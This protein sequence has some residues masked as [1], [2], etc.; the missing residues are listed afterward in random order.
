MFFMT[1]SVAHGAAAQILSRT[2]V[3][4]ALPVFLAKWAA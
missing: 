3:P 2:A 4:F 1:P